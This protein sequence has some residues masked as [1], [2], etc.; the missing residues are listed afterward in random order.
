MAAQAA[1]CSHRLAQVGTLNGWQ[2][3]GL[4]GEAIG[5]GD[6]D[7]GVV[8]EAEM[9]ASD[10]DVLVTSRRRQHDARHGTMASERL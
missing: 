8:S 9:A 4:L 10:L 5:D 1:A 2:F 7:G 3:P 6:D